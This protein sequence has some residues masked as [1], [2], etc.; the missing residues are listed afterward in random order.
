MHGSDLSSVGKDGDAA[1]LSQYLLKEVD[2]E[3][4]K[5]RPTYRGSDEDLQTIAEWLAQ[6]K[7]S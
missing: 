4:K 1:W 6:Q 5:H 7:G 3:G 2:V